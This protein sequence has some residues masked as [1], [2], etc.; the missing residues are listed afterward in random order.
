MQ[1]VKYYKCPT[2][3]KKYQSLVT[4]SNH[5]LKQHPKDIP[6]GF[7]PARYFYFLQ[8]G[9]KE[10]SCIVCK[11][12]TEWNEATAKYNRFCNNPQCKEKY[13]EEFKKRMLGKYGK[14][15]LLDDPAQQR[16]MLEAK[17]NSGKY[18]FRD[19]GE[20]GYVSTYELDFLKMLDRF[21]EF[22]SNDIMGPSPHTYY[23]DYKNPEDKENEGRKFYIPDYYI[24]SLNLE[25]EIK[26]NTS[27]H[28]KILRI[29]KVKE[30]QKD[31]LMKSNKRVKYIKIT[32]K[33][34]EPFF[35]LLLDMKEQIPTEKEIESNIAMQPA[36]E[37]IGVNNTLSKIIKFNKKTNLF[38]YGLIN[39]KK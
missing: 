10:G 38:A 18:K 30:E 3:N 8:T 29:D 23:Y 13:R 21:L 6:A 31:A 34:Y 5:M 2:C 36:T 27:T 11:N 33:K 1:K 39:P 24:P 9:K 15:N 25:I 7:T 32:D 14:V 26:Q 19:G 35:K 20:V 37:S 22:N 12:P 17:R 28:P 4:W 16:K